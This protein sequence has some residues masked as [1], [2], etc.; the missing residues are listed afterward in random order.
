MSIDTLIFRKSRIHPGEF[1]QQRAPI[2]AIPPELVSIVERKIIGDH[3]FL[4]AGEGKPVIFC[5]GLF[6][7]IFNIEKVCKAISV[8]YRFIMP[9]LP[10]YDLPLKDCTVAKLG[11]YL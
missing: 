1:L 3:I 10:M 4:D 2:R 8:K 6:G 7:G 5:H 11:E 9:Y